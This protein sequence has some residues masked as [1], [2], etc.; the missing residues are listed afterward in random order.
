[1]NRKILTAFIFAAASFQ[2]AFAFEVTGALS[3]KKATT[4]ET[5]CKQVPTTVTVAT[6]RTICTV[7]P[8]SHSKSDD[9]AANGECYP[10]TE[11]VASTKSECGVNKIVT[12]T[13]YRARCTY[14]NGMGSNCSHTVVSETRTCTTDKGL[15][16]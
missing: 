8:I 1:M 4:Y 16:C 2:P 15:A 11:Q 12:T 10:E 9:F 3:T 5:V 13:T 6:G 14:N 7:D